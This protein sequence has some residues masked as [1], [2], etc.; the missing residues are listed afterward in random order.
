ML[1]AH[2]R[3]NI[4]EVIL[5]GNRFSFAVRLGDTATAGK[6]AIC[7]ALTILVMGVTWMEVSLPAVVTDDSGSTRRIARASRLG[8][9]D[10]P[11]VTG[12]FNG[13]LRIKI[14]DPGNDL[15]YL[16]SDLMSDHEDNMV[17]L[18]VLESHEL[19]HVKYLMEGG[20]DNQK[21]REAAVDLENKVRK[22][23]FPNGPTRVKH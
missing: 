9:G 19:G 20:R 12:F 11:G 4:S 22:I 21:N 16:P 2:D 7:S 18:S 6:L 8:T 17:T 23:Q 3:I 10:S 14:L 15:G 13:Q 5:T 1:P